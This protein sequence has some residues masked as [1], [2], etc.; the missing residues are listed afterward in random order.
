MHLNSFIFVSAEVNEC[1]GENNCAETA[2]CENTR[3]SYK[4]RCV[5]DTIGNGITCTREFM[6]KKKE[7]FKSN[8]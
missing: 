3:G 2:V 8:F 7:K 1:L 6:S 4:C 5:N